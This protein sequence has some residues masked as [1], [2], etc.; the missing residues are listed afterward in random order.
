MAG[1]T[2]EEIKA[3]R[4]RAIKALEEKGYEVINTF[5]ED[6]WASKETLTE[7]GIV[8]FPLYFLAKSLAKM[9]LVHAVY[10][11]RGWEEARGCRIEHA[12]ATAYKLD[13]IY[14][15]ESA[16]GEK[17]NGYHESSQNRNIQL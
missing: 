7:L 13:V 2:K 8:H 10:F 17:E 12:A 16:G 3:T 4:E 1:K 14:E 9:S 15:E 5:F 6:A 11:C